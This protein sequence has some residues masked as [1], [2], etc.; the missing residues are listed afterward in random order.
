MVDMTMKAVRQAELDAARIEKEA[1]VKK[2]T[3]L[4]KVQIQIVAE[5]ETIQKQSVKETKAALAEAELQCDNE[6]KAAIIRANE[7]IA[8][9]KEKVDAKKSDA[10]NLIIAELV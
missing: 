3:I 4:E 10:V 9:L 2:D 5:R 8:L 6:K 1:V 7:E